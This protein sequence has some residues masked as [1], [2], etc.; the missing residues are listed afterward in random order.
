MPSVVH[1]FNPTMM[2]DH[3][4]FAFTSSSLSPTER[5]YS[6]IEKECLAICN[7]FQKFDQWLY[8]KSD[9][10]VHMNHQPLET[11][12]TKPLNTAP[13]HLRRMLMRLQCYCFKLMYKREPTL[14]LAN[15]LS[16]AAPTQQVAAKV[17]HF[18][19]L[20]RDGVWTELQ[21]PKTARKQWAPLTR[22]DRQ[23]HH[24]VSPVQSKNPWMTWRQSSHV[25]VP[26]SVLEL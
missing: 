10:Q 23:G 17:T 5:H 8:G 24:T 19:L 20:S 3:N 22:R 26:A 21:K 15:T 7:C 12:M 2:A 6:Q 1:L 13:A 18:C 9:I 25:W 14:H 4:Q 16:H 11:I